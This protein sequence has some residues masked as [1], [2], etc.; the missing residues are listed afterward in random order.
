M[1]T[2]LD[3]QLQV[4]HSTTY[5][6]DNAS[7]R[8]KTR[9][10]E[11]SALYDAQTVRH[12]EQRGVG[13][14]WSCL[15]VGGGGGSVASWLCTRVG[16]Q[17]RVLAT[18]IDPQFLQ[19]LT[20]ANL[21]VRRHDIRTEGL[22]EHQFDLAHARLVLVHLP[23]RELALQRMLESLKPGGWIV[24]EEIDDLSIL[25]DSSINPGEEELLVRH[26]FQHVL[27]AREVE[28]R[29]GRLL[30]QKLRAHGLLNVGAEA[31]VSIWKAHSAGTTLLKLSCQE[32]RDSI[33][34]SGLISQAQ[35]DAEMKRVDDED[36]LMPSPMMWTAWGQVPKLP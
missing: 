2:I 20:Y 34:D 10:R 13:N 25:P 12:L 23:E 8:A 6:F 28:L 16:D 5:I 22:P 21:E 35:F 24:I 11:L 18:D 33:I 26:A 29:Y 19:A 1:Q 14:G 32:L 30:P 7:E 27:T 3:K 9:Y 36:F 4:S 17:G 15:E 31:S